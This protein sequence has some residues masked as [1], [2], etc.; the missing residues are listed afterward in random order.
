MF[1]YNVQKLIPRVNSNHI[2]KIRLAA[3]I[4]TFNVLPS[5]SLDLKHFHVLRHRYLHRHYLQ[6]KNSGATLILYENFL[7]FLWSYLLYWNHFESITAKMHFLI[8]N[9]KNAFQH[10]SEKASRNWWW[11]DRPDDRP[12]DHPVVP[13][14]LPGFYLKVPMK[15]QV[16]LGFYFYFLRYNID[17]F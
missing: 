16:Q 10:I 4:S 7:P 17:L 9:S 6:K 12:D 2:L 14:W 5:S 3:C 11:D 1:G 15:V 13:F 8:N